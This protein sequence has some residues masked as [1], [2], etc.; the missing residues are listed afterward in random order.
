MVKER[1]S[2][3]QERSLYDCL[4]AHVKGERIH[5]AKGHRFQSEGERDRSLNL[6]RLAKGE[7]LV[8]GVCQEC[9]WL[10]GTSKADLRDNRGELEAVKSSRE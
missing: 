2:S 10:D 4:H 5:C 7:P 9:G 6:Q 1:D 8:M 3:I